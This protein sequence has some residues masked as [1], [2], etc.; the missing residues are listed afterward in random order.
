MGVD[1][2]T[3]RDREQPRANRRRVAHLIGGAKSGQHRLL[4]DV[5]GALWA[6]LC[7]AEAQQRTAVLLDDALEAEW[8]AHPCKTAAATDP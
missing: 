8:R 3:R 2:L 1:R 4:E 5:L 6:D 7:G